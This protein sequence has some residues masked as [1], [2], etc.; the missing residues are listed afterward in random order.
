MR[1][2]QSCPDDLCQAQQRLADARI[3]AYAEEARTLRPPELN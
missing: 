3:R 1:A 2:C